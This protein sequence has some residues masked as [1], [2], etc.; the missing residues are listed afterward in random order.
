MYVCFIKNMLFSKY[1]TY[2]TLVICMLTLVTKKMDKNS[3]QMSE[4]GVAFM[5]I[6]QGVTPT[7]WPWCR[8]VVRHLRVVETE[9][10]Q[11]Y[12]DNIKISLCSSLVQ[13]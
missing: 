4:L 6:G 9:N 2:N 11:L 3:P 8:I 1:M 13:L 7:T 12:R 5:W 10:I